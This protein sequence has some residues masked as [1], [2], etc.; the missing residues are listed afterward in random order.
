MCVDWVRCIAA[1][2][3]LFITGPQHQQKRTWITEGTSKWLTIDAAGMANGRYTSP[4]TVLGWS[5]DWYWSG[6]P[7]QTVTATLWVVD[8]VHETFLPLVGR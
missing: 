7:S 5:Y 1:G 6:V 8:A 3:T 4:I 2:R